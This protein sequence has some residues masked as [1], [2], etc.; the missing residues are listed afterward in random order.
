MD[1]AMGIEVL[2]TTTD[3]LPHTV[4]VAK[5]R[6]IEVGLGRGVERH[7]DDSVR[8]VFEEPAGKQFILTMQPH[9]EI[10]A[11]S[12]GAPRNTG[13]A[14]LAIIVALLPGATI[15]GTNPS[16]DTDLG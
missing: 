7:H 11:E 6:A 16:W 2:L 4:G 10:H 14:D 12:F 8:L 5:A 3:P 13:E 1:T 15:V 9:G